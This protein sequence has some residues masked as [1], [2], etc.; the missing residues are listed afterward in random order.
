MAR[1]EFRPDL[2]ARQAARALTKGRRAA[3]GLGAMGVRHG[4]PV[5]RRAG[6]GLLGLLGWLIGLLAALARRGAAAYEARRDSR[7]ERRA[8]AGLGRMGRNDRWNRRRRSED[9]DDGLDRS[10]SEA[11]RRWEME[12]RAARDLDR[13]ER[14]RLKR[15]EGAW[16]LASVGAGL[17]V[18]GATM[19]GLGP[20]G[21]I[22]LGLLVGALIGWLGTVVNASVAS[23]QTKRTAIKV[24][25]RP[26]IAAPDVNESALPNGRAELVQ[27][28]LGD[29]ATALRALD[30]VVPTLRHPDSVASVARIVA[31]G[32]RLMQGVAAA[33]EKLSIVQRVF[34]YYCP[35]TVKVAEALSRLEREV[36]PDLDRI[37]GTQNVLKKLEMLFERS[38]LELKADE[39]KALDID[40]RL[41]DQSLESDLKTR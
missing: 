36:Q 39:S 18:F 17:L 13:E 24:P 22:G 34:T 35:E 19:D 1:P 41:L 27:K 28:V 14:R 8:L 26:E 5:A 15:I 10:V 3:L 21:N 2:A 16:R 11:A 38:E 9:D 25:P 30:A 31:V 40:L 12:L 4:G 37:H 32:N 29:A 6:K 7:E 23:A 33:P 20:P